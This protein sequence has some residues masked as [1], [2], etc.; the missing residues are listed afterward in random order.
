[1]GGPRCEIDVI[2]LLAGGDERR[3]AFRAPAREALQGADF[4]RLERELAERRLLPLIGSRVIDAAP[5]LVPGSFRAAVANALAAARARGMVIEAAMQ[6]AV[7][8]LG[9]AGIR[10]LPLKGPLLAQEAYGDIGLRETA[11]IDLL[12]GAAQL[13]PAVGILRGLDYS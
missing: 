3:A 8:A 13:E 10:A 1:M 4:E 12:V 2:A 9:G 7:H 5:D 11:D 6:R